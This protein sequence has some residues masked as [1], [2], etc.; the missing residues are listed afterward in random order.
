MNHTHF[1][2][3]KGLCAISCKHDWRVN[4]FFNREFVTSETFIRTFLLVIEM[5]RTWYFDIC[6]Q[7]S[8]FSLRHVAIL[9][10]LCIFLMNSECTLQLYFWSLKIWPVFF[11]S[12]S[13]LIV[14]KSYYIYSFYW[15]ISFVLPINPKA[16]LTIVT[17]GHFLTNKKSALTA[18]FANVFFVTYWFSCN[19]STILL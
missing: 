11:A 18:I 17:I 13:W 8:S 9:L 16:H 19:Y 4:L 10:L 7:I 5:Q 15:K 3:D 14:S 6:C 2:Q 1:K 12:I